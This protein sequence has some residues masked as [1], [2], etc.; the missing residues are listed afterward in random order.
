M[1]RMF[2]ADVSINSMGHSSN[3]SPSLSLTFEVSMSF[4]FL[5]TKY[6]LRNRITQRKKEKNT[7]NW[8]LLPVIVDFHSYFLPNV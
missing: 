6:K 1:T 5:T 8:W 4:S 3:N 7:R 2:L